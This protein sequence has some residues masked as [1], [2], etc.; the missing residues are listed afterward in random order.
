MSKISLWRVWAL[1]KTL[2]RLPGETLPSCLYQTLCLKNAKTGRVFAEYT[3]MI[4]FQVSLL[5]RL[6]SSF[7]LNKPKKLAIT[8]K[9]SFRTIYP[10]FF[11]GVIITLPMSIFNWYFLFVFISL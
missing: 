5:L 11:P 9:V 2:L 10:W 1:S 4:N 3:F 6:F 7:Y 8:V